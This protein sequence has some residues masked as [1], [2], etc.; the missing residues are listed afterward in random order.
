MSTAEYYKVEIEVPDLGGKAIAHLNRANLPL[1]MYTLYKYLLDNK[2][3]TGRARW[4]D[5]E[6]KDALYFDVRLH[7]GKEGQP[8]TLQRGELG[9]SYKM[10]SIYIALADQPSLPVDTAKLGEVIE[11]IE[12]F[13]NARNGASVKMKLA[14]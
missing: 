11:G 6:K 9:Y 5:P 8:G 4:Q 10:D 1:T 7:R 13:E 12:L 3:I 2:F 14:K